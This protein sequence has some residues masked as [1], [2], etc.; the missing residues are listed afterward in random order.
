MGNF[1]RGEGSMTSDGRVP[2]YC[3]PGYRFLF[4]DRRIIPRIHLDGMP[5][6]ALV[7]VFGMDSPVGS[8]GTCILRAQVGPDG[9]VNFSEPI[10]VRAGTGF[11]VLPVGTSG[12]TNNLL[13]S[14]T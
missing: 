5:E 4:E 14:A 10:I 11:L 3:D 8:A 7:D 6:G 2:L 1:L 9:W 13:E 12:T